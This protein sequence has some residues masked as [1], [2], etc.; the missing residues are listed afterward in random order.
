LVSL[1]GSN[2]IV[3]LCDFIVWSVYAGCEAQRRRAKQHMNKKR[4]CS[5]FVIP[6]HTD[7]FCLQSGPSRRV[8]CFT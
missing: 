3:T 2:F 8:D 6:L 1:R 4:I 5:V 7:L